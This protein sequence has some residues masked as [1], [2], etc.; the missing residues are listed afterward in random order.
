MCNTNMA[1]FN[2]HLVTGAAVGA[3]TGAGLSVL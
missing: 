1:N 2:K 3:V